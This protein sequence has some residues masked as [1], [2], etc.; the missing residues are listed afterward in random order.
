[1]KIQ[2]I[3][4]TALLI[5]G[6]I[7]DRAQAGDINQHLAD[8]VVGAVG[9]ACFYYAIFSCCADHTPKKNNDEQEK[10]EAATDLQ[11]IAESSAV[12]SSAPIAQDCLIQSG[13]SVKP[14]LKP[15]KP[16]DSHKQ[17]NLQS[18]ADDTTLQHSMDVA[19]EAPYI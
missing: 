11:A 5:G 2:K 19:I 4:L 16:I 17:S 12:I 8:V 14:Q 3:A 15:I 18:I 6:M 7:E 10:E 9:V 13:F 1:M